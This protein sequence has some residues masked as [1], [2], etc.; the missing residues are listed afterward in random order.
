MARRPKPWAVVLRTPGAPIRSEHT[1]QKKAYETVRDAV[2]AA[3]AGTS[4]TIGIR[5][6]QW[7]ADYN[8]WVLY[9]DID[10]KEQQ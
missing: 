8:R 1:S 9:D 5:I 4:R 6:E 2:A 3:K 10:P 7:E